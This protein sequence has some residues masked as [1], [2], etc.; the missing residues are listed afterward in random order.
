MEENMRTILAVLSL[1]AGLGLIF[2]QSASAYPVDA[3]AIQQAASAASNIE[4]TQFYE[5]HTRHGVVKCYRDL[6][7]GRYACHWY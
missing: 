2:S 4:H 1:A 7:I 3:A 5:R 6:V